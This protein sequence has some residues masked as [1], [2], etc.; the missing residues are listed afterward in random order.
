MTEDEIM[1]Q[2]FFARLAYYYGQVAEVLKGNAEI[3]S[4]FPNTT[5]IGMSREVIY[6]EVLRKHSPSSLNVFL[7]GFLFDAKGNESKQLD[8]IATAHSA[9]RFDL[10]NS[11][12][13]GKSFANVEG[14]VGVASIKST[15]DRKEIR[16]ALEGLASIPT[17]GSPAYASNLISVPDYSDWPYKIVYASD[18]I[19][20]DTLM[21]HIMEFYAENQHIPLERRPNLIHV[22]GK[23]TIVRS[24]KGHKFGVA[25]G[26]D[27]FEIMPG[28]YIPSNRDP[29]IQGLML[30][31]FEMQKKA[32]EAN[33][34]LF[35]QSTEFY[36]NF[37]R[38]RN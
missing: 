10:L 17:T 27:G 31:A 23:Y 11:S 30:V 3:A 6:A 19:A 28:Q 25:N 37:V 2:P 32:N 29:D 38:S 4:I 15:L 36:E 35:S 13:I 24:I 20:Q 5:D 9:G 22:L 21:S 12:G 33:H 7:G 14:A 26:K 8:V 34:L 16:D 18:G 1:P